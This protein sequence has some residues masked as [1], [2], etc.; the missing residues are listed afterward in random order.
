MGLDMVQAALIAI[1]RRL[2]SCMRS[3]IVTFTHNPNTCLNT[4]HTRPSLPSTLPLPH[5]KCT[6]NPL[7]IPPHS[8]NVLTRRALLQLLL[9]LSISLL[10][11]A[12]LDV[13]PTIAVLHPHAEPE[14]IPVL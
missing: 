8:P 9:L 6:H 4:Y 3:R 1:N 5:P 14:I 7:I 13:P 12:L 10:H 11:H 2:A